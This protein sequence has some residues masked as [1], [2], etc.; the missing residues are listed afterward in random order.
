MKNKANYQQMLLR[1]IEP[2]KTRYREDCTGL[3][4]GVTAAG[5]GNRIAEMEGFSRVLW[6][7]VSYWAGGGKDRSL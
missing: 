6:G 7:M 3:R 4:L 2:L 1:M 5:Y